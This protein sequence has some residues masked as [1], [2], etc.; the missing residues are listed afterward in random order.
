MKKI[1]LI[2]ICLAM[3]IAGYIIRPANPFANAQEN[4]PERFVHLQKQSFLDTTL[5]FH[6]FKDTKTD[7]ELLVVILADDDGNAVAVK[8]LE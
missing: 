3:L 1:F 6:V 5:Q 8:T 7:K 2:L 4:K